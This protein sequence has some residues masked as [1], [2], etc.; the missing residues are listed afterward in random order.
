MSTPKSRP[1][2]FHKDMVLALLAG[3][4]TQTRRLVKPQ[5][6]KQSKWL[7]PGLVQ[8]VPGG[9]MINGGWQMFHPKAGT[10]HTVD[11]LTVNES[12]DSP[13]SWI[14]CP[15]GEPGDRLWVKETWLRGYRYVGGDM[16]CTDENGNDLE[17]EVFYKA[18]DD[19]FVWHDDDGSPTETVPWKSPRFMPR[20]ASRIE[21]EIVSVRVERLN[22]IS[23]ADA[24]AEGVKTWS[25]HV[26]KDSE[27]A[28]GLLGLMLMRSPYSNQYRALWESIN[29]KG[30]WQD[31]PYV[32]VIEFK[33]VP[34]SSSVIPPPSNP[35]E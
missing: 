23:E 14:K 18:T 29:G 11:G 2:P 30:S 26:S 25:D 3:T 8:Q 15:Y 6:G 33:Q 34:P 7:T 24:E 28:Y 20:W 5:R 22:E 35:A 32:W 10:T 9:Y 21:L 1:I 4:K 17:P 27:G 12:A 31:N 13:L 16:I 19:N